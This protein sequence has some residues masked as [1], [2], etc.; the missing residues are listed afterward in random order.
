[1]GDD[2]HVDG[3]GIYVISSAWQVASYRMGET[4]SSDEPGGGNYGGGPPIRCDDFRTS[5]MSLTSDSVVF[6][7]DDSRLELFPVDEHGRAI[8]MR[9]PRR[10]TVWK[11]I[12]KCC[13][14]DVIFFSILALLCVLIITILII[15]R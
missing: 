11:R 12:S 1:M 6:V 4:S 13:N 5:N 9:T 15:D 3:G 10:P 8:P 2:C 14:A 7:G